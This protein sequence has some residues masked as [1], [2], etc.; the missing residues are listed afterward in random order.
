MHANGLSTLLGWTQWLDFPVAQET[1]KGPSTVL[2]FL[3]IDFNEPHTS[4][5]RQEAQISERTAGLLEG[6]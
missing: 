5:A 6:Y 4:F 2:T 3:G 1:V